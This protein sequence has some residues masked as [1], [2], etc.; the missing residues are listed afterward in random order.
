MSWITDS[1]SITKYKNRPTPI[2]WIEVPGIINKGDYI[3]TW[4]DG[5]AKLAS[6][7]PAHPN[8]RKIISVKGRRVGWLFIDQ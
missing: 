2:D 7:F 3:I 1:E 8:S 4:D 5:R 6:R